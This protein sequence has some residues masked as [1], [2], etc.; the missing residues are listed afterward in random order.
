MKDHGIPSLLLF[1]TLVVSVVKF[2][3][4]DMRKLLLIVIILLLPTV[5]SAEWVDADGV[6]QDA[7]KVYNPSSSPSLCLDSSGYAH[8]AFYSPTDMDV[9]YLKWNGTTWVDADGV[10]QGEINVSNTGVTPGSCYPS[11]CLDSSWRPHIAWQE[12]AFASEEIF[13]LEWD[14]TS[15]VDADGVGQ[16]NINVSNNGGSSTLVSLC[17]DS[18]NNPH[19]AWAD[20]S[21]GNTEVYYLKWNG[22]AWVD[23]DGVGQAQINVS[24][25]AGNSTA[26]SLFLNST[27]NPHI[28]WHDNTVGNMEIY[29]L[30]WDGT[31]WVDADGVG[32]GDINVSNTADNSLWPSLCLDTS[33]NAHIA[34][35]GGLFSF[36]IRYLK[37]NGAA[38]VDVDGTGLGDVAVYGGITGNSSPSLVL[39]SMGNPQIAWVQA[40]MI[41]TSNACFLKW[42]G[43]SWVDADG[44]GQESLVIFGL[45]EPNLPSLCIDAVDSPHVAASCYDF[46]FPGGGSYAGYLKWLA[47]TP[48]VTVSATTS[49]TRTVTPTATVSA[50]LTPTPTA[51]A[52]PTCSGTHTVTA[53]ITQTGTVPPSVTITA[54]VTHTSAPPEEEDLFIN[55]NIFNPDAGG[56]VEIRWSDLGPG[57]VSLVIYNTAGELVKRLRGG[58]IHAAGVSETATWDGRNEKGDLVASGVY[59]VYLEG[60]RSFLGK[61]AVVK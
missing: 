39:D 58:G 7:V 18:G 51:T 48:T 34:W 28:A 59:I 44:V 17:L 32:Q 25:N 15:W 26:P 37:W 30:Y 23:A 60:R 9:Y 46:A 5:L 19:I 27:G 38:W 53:T 61:V 41:F 14:G 56:T 54:T 36:E 40:T 22:A 57:K 29:Y 13:Y 45:G 21:V 20:N 6:G 42:D 1:A 11:L 3:K 35:G 10:G 12:G 47:P 8:V 4:E 2:K 33:G 50:S 31:A 49:P 55:R 16:G 43:T 52:T 24:N